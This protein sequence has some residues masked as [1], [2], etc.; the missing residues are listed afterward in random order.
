MA[1]LERELAAVEKMKKGFETLAETA[2]A[3]FKA[4]LKEVFEE[5]S[6]RGAETRRLGEVCEFMTS[7]SRGRAKLDHSLNYYS[8]IQHWLY[9]A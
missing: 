1:R 9:A 5:I 6:R 7:G 4:E 3:E 2:K 8:D